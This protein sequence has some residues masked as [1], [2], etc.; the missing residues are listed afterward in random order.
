MLGKFIA[1][2]ILLALMD[3]AIP[4][5]MR[6]ISAGFFSP[7]VYDVDIFYKAYGKGYIFRFALSVAMCLVFIV[8]VYKI[9]IFAV[10][11]AAM[12]ALVVSYAAVVVFFVLR[13]REASKIG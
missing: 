6:T 7:K 4:R 5:N 3:W 9:N 1:F 11:A 8:L 2:V 12:I 13:A 10:Q